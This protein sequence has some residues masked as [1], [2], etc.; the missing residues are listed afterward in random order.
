MHSGQFAPRFSNA[1][2]SEW[3]C[4]RLFELRGNIAGQFDIVWVQ[5]SDGCAWLQ[6]EFFRSTQITFGLVVSSK[7]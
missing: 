1:A 5:H 3:S 7:K 4:I 2:R 6:V